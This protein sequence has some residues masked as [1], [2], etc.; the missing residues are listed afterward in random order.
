MKRY[1]ELT[2][3]ERSQRDGLSLGEMLKGLPGVQSLQ[4]GSTVSKPIIHGLHSTRV[5]VLNQGVRQEGQNWGSEHAPEIDPFVSKRIQVIKG[6]AGLRYGG[7]AIGGIVIIA[8]EVLKKDTLVGKTILNLANNGMGGSLSSSIQKGNLLGWS[9]NALGTF[10]YLGDR[11]TPD[12]VLSNSG[13]RE[14]N[15]TGGIR[16]AKEKY[17]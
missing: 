16:F 2:V 13:N 14:Q 8:P 10:K 4:T 15:F 12:Y 6:P 11:E 17:I 9:W 7:D 1:T 3:E 5:V